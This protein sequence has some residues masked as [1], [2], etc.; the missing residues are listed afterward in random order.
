[1]HHHKILPLIRDLGQRTQELLSQEFEFMGLGPGQIRVLTA[2]LA[3][4]GI[5]QNSLARA[6]NLNKSTIS[7]A[8]TILSRAGYVEIRSLTGNKKSLSILP[9]NLAK[10]LI[11]Q[12]SS[13]TE[14]TESVIIKSLGPKE[15]QNFGQ[16]LKTISVN[17]DSLIKQRRNQLATEPNSPTER[18]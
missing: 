3:T 1:M 7:R 16:N 8:V 15:A 4:P 9:T 12:M 11:P 17:L 6:T 2:V 10:S 13:I 14:D 5:N 18:T